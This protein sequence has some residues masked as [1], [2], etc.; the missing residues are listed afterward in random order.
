[1]EGSKVRREEA[2]L[3]S[4]DGR[5]TVS[6]S[7]RPIRRRRIIIITLRRITNTRCRIQPRSTDTRCT[8]GMGQMTTPPFILRCLLH[9]LR[10]KCVGTKSRLKSK[11]PAKIY[12]ILFSKHGFSSLLVFALKAGASDS[13]LIT[14]GSLF[15]TRQQKLA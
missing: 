13:S 15:Q 8:A 11:K 1:M 2:G 12:W 6:F 14:A 7:S 10:R 5:H 3:C 9:S 4:G